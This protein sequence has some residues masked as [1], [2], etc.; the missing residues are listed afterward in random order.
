MPEQEKANTTAT[1]VTGST[2]D[3]GTTT[4]DAVT[5]EQENDAAF[6]KAKAEHWKG[7][8]RENESKWKKATKPE[9][10]KEAPKD[11]AKPTVD[12]L[13]QYRTERVRDKVQD[14]FEAFAEAL[15]ADLN[16]VMKHVT[17]E[18]FLDEGSVKTDD[19]K[20]YVERFATPKKGGKFVQGVGVG[21]Q[22]SSNGPTI[23]QRIAE[24]QKA[25]DTLSVIALRREKALSNSAK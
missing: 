16:E 15:G 20:A 12:P 21:P 18:S 13:E 19:I 8:S 11:E 24:A 23:D 4:D 14:K 10:T 17:I 25:G 5:P 3:T 22:G 1:D 6:W 2:T 7:M 9:P